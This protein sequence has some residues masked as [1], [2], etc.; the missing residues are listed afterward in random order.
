MFSLFFT[1]IKVRCVLVYLAIFCYRKKWIKESVIKFYVKNKMKCS[2]V[3]KMLTAS[4]DESTLSKKNVYKW[5]KLFTEGREDVNDDARPGRPS[6]STT[7]ETL[8]KWRKLLSS[9][10]Y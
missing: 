7:D 5:Y 1:D 2:N 10:H 4:F 6:M 3:L 8:K 9:N